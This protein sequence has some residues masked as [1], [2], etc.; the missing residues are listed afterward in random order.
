MLNLRRLAPFASHLLHNRCNAAAAAA[1]KAPAPANPSVTFKRATK[2]PPSLAN[3]LITCKQKRFNLEAGT[4]T[5]P[6][7][8]PK[9]GTI[10]LASAGWKHHKAKGDFFTIHPSVD[11]VT[12]GSDETTAAVDDE[13]LTFDTFNLDERLLAN[14]SALLATRD[15]SA[16]Q[17]RALP[18][19]LTGNHTLIA[20]ETGC[21]KTLAYLV[22]I[23]QQ[24]VQRKK[25][26]AMLH[27]VGVDVDSEF[28]APRAL[29]LTPGRELGKVLNAV[30][31]L[32]PI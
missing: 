29:V 15:C 1:T 6:S 12:I 23:V 17:A 3:P 11:I 8:V 5:L 13:P 32:K 4:K 16:I 2:N 31:E 19:I 25:E 24:L 14:L 7:V 26:L 30:I 20:A 10:E 9:F 18:Q 22:P 28:N 27:S 21:G